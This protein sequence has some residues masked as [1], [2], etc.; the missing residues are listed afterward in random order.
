MSFK[1]IYQWIQIACTTLPNYVLTGFKQV[2]FILPI[3]I[4][5]L[6]LSS[7]GHA[8]FSVSG[9]QLLDGRGEPF[10]MRGIN[11]AHTWYAGETS[12]FANIAATGANTIRVVLSNGQR[13]QR[14]SAD[15]VAQVIE[16]CKENLL[17]CV[18]EVHDAT[19]SGE[20]SAAGSIAG[21]AAYWADIA[22]VLQGE[23]D[24]I[25]INIANEPI[26]NNQPASAWIDQHKE[27]I[28]IIRD[29]GLNHTLV[30]DAANWGQDWEQIMLSWASEVAAVD[31]LNNTIFSVHMYQIYPD[32]S[33]IENYVATFLSTHNL[34]LIV[35]EFGWSHQGE[36]VDEDSIMAVAEDYGIGYIGWSWSGNTDPYLDLVYDFDPQNLSS[37]GERL[38][39]GPD[40]IA[41]TA[42][43]AT[44]YDGDDGDG[45]DDGDD[46]DGDDGNPLA[47]CQHLIISAWPDGFQGLI[48]IQ[49]TSS[50]VIDSWTVSWNYTDGSV[51]T[52]TWNAAVSGANPY[53]A[54]NL[55]WNGRIEPGQAVEFGFIGVGLGSASEVAGSVCN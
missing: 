40:G 27:A 37:W 1:S 7:Q 54:T 23:E 47:E 39:Y 5:S 25:L 55:G 10:V 31:Q 32:L 48:R 13:W 24:Y 26:G 9:T 43:R 42:K 36:D 18:L 16:L 38:I 41:L 33:T 6:I 46:G 30:V 15:D 21:A 51:L 35:G 8:G 12:S 52:Q 3:I 29:A 4:S 50:S 45:G 53:T 22:P 34:P 11:H 49:N 14:N 19:G 44:V 20:D 28:G 17:I 2:K